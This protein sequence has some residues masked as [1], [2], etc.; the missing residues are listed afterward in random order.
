MCVHAGICNTEDE[1]TSV[2]AAAPSWDV[3]EEQ[4]FTSMGE[5]LSIYVFKGLLIHHAAWTFLWLREDE[6]GDC[7]EMA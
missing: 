1:Q 2:K 5:E 6:L 4:R 3:S 7:N